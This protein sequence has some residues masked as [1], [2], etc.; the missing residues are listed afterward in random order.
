M[1][2]LLAKDVVVH[3]AVSLVNPH[4]QALFH[5][6]GNVKG[7][8]TERNRKKEEKELERKK[9]ERKKKEMEKLTS[10]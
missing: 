10:C 4:A 1:N 5:G 2:L 9:E 8:G 3:H 6:A 7:N